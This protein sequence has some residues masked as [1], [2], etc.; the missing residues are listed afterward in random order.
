M[1]IKKKLAY[2]KSESSGKKDN[3][4]NIGFAPLKALQECF[5]GEICVPSAPY[6][7]IIRH[8]QFND[9]FMPA[10]EINKTVKLDFL[11]KGQINSEIDPEKCLFF[12]LETTGL[13]GGAGT[14]AFLLGF[15]MIKNNCLN[16]HQYFLPD[17]GREYYPFK[18]LL[19]SFKEFSF[20]ASY[21]GKSYDLPLLKTRFILNRLKQNFDSFKHIDLLHIA[22][23]IW[24]DSLK[25]CDLIS[26]ENNL[27]GRRRSDDIPGAFIPQAYFDFIRTGVIHNIKRIIDHNY[28]DIVSLA[29]LFILSSQIESDP[30][31]VKDSKARTRL[32][33]LAFERQN[34]TL[35]ENIVSSACQ[36]SKREQ[37]QLNVWQSLLYKKKRKWTEAAALWQDLISSKEYMFFALEELAKYYEHVQRDIQRALFFTDKAFQFFDTFDQLKSGISNLEEKRSFRHRRKRLIIKL[38]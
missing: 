29:E 22:R 34:E 4:T 17:F 15:G 2:Y 33:R 5:N 8:H 3:L 13:A 21:N 6:L 38:S 19:E 37:D 12:D 26:I 23:R 32:A 1:D 24:K 30:L 7:K 10:L 28:Y 14:F 9:K 16:V 11:T 25:S 27:L 36:V 20:L 35:F 31:I 18:T